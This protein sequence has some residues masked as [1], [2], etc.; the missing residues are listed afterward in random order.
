VGE[1]VEA[2]TTRKR[3]AVSITDHDDVPVNPF[4]PVPRSNKRPKRATV[5]PLTPSLSYYSTNNYY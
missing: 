5:S 1:I 4:A 2:S 3:T